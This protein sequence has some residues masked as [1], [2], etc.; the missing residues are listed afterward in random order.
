VAKQFAEKLENWQAEQASAAKAAPFQ[1]RFKSEAFQQTV[2][3]AFLITGAAR[4][5]AVPFQ[6]TVPTSFSS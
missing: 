2:K 1:S 4:L 3:P 6:K 5:E